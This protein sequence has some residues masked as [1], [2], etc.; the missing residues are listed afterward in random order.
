MTASVLVPEIVPAHGGSLE[1]HLLGLVDFDAWMGLQEYQ[2]YQLS[3]RTDLSGALFLCGHPVS[4]SMGRE[5]S[6][7]DLL[8]DDEELSRRE[9]EVRWVSRGG[10]AICHAPGQLAIYLQIPLKRLNIGLSRFR[11]LFEAA[12]VAACQELKI[13]AKRQADAT[14]VW[15]RG[16]QLGYFG[17]GVKSWI[18]CSGMFLNLT[19]DSRLLELTVSHTGG[20]R[21]TSMQSIRLDPVRM[22]QIRESLIRHIA[23]HFGYVVTDISTGHPLLRRTKKRVL[24][25]A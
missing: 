20:G 13:P 6:R 4:I 3:G 11:H 7:A 12:V 1:V 23:T 17:A 8:L 25:H 22:P 16:G 21:S 19:I 2:I 24:I 14:G 15:T 10:G 18:S 5:A 9:L